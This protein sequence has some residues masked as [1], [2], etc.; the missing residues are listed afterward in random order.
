M[1]CRIWILGPII[2][3]SNDDSGMT[4]TYFIAISNLLTKAFGW[5]KNETNG[6]FESIEDS[7]TKFGRSGKLNE[8]M[9]IFG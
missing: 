7:V 6:I 3:C 1:A 5:E 9:K 4:L 2:I 8:L